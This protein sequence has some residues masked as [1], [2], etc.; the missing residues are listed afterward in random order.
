MFLSDPVTIWFRRRSSGSCDDALP[1]SFAKPV[2]AE[3]TDDKDKDQDG[4]E[5]QSVGSREDGS[6]AVFSSSPTSLDSPTASSPCLPFRRGSFSRSKRG[7]GE[8]AAAE[9]GKKHGKAA[10]KEESA[11]AEGGVKKKVPRM[12]W[13]SKSSCADSKIAHALTSGGRSRWRDKNNAADALLDFEQSGLNAGGSNTA[14]PPHRHVIRQHTT[15]TILLVDGDSPHRL[16]RSL[17]N[18][19]DFHSSSSLTDVPASPRACS[20]LSISPSL[21]QH[22]HHLRSPSL[23]VSPPYSPY[24]SPSSPL[25]PSSPTAPYSSQYAQ[26]LS[27]PLQRHHRQPTPQASPPPAPGPN[28]SSSLRRKSSVFLNRASCFDFESIPDKLRAL[29]EEWRANKQQRRRLSRLSRQEA[30]VVPPAAAPDTC[31]PRQRPS[32]SNSR[33]SSR[34]PRA[35]SPMPL[36]YEDYVLYLYSLEG[37][38]GVPQLHSVLSQF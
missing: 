24:P 21:S 18:T 37:K 3:S 14:S 35:L 2:V 36:T 29:Q 28:S 23:S 38:S 8:G 30:K 17:S 20:K 1:P 31:S 22:R 13:R 11:S 12:L 4:S 10:G 7:Q 33:S 9:K 19:G 15:P 5:E 27:P 6:S 34:S 32:R 26:C 25:S 16:E